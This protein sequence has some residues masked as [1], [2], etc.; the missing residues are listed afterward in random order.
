MVSIQQTLIHY[1]ILYVQ[2][3]TNCNALQYYNYC[4]SVQELAI[5]GG[6]YS[7]GPDSHRSLAI[8]TNQKTDNEDSAVYKGKYTNL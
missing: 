7:S 4:T 3:C 8:A 6:S 5:K 1:F 2:S